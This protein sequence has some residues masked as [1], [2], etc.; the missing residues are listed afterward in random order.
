MTPAAPLIHL[1][2]CNRAVGVRNFKQLPYISHGVHLHLAKVQHIGIAIGQRL[3]AQRV[4]TR[5]RG[6]GTGGQ[7]VAQL[8]IVN[9]QEGNL[10]GILPALGLQL[11]HGAQDLSQA[12]GDQALGLLGFT[13]N[14]LRKRLVR[15][16]LKAFP[17]T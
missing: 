11:L 15:E 5:R 13:A 7:Q 4:G 17:Q 12:A 9:L 14:H 16:Q 1:R 2:R 3:N 10:Q 6:S 8:L